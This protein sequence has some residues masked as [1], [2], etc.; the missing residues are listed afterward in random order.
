MMKLTCAQQARSKA[1]TSVAIAVDLGSDAGGK[2]SAGSGSG[3]LRFEEE[4]KK[5]Q[6]VN[7]AAE[8]VTG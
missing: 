8:Q 3:A 2:A 4:L 5:I 6:A 7:E 1:P